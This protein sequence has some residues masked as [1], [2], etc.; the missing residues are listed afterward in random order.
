M[1][2]FQFLNSQAS[3][4]TVLLS[5]PLIFISCSETKEKAVIP[6]TSE[7]APSDVSPKETESEKAKVK[8]TILAGGY[9][10]TYT[11]PDGWSPELSTPFRNINFSFA[12]QGEVYLSETRGG[13]LPNINRWY[14]QL[15]GSSIESLDQLESFSVLSGKGYLVSVEGAF[16]SMRMPQA[17][18]GYMLLGVLVEID[19]ELTTVKMIGPKNE[20]SVQKENLVAFCKSL[21]RKK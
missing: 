7:E 8:T 20:V 21:E 9:Q 16:K 19:G 4:V 15:G 5:V 11:M 14:G 2:I 6:S 12:T 3:K 17:K 1:H 10:Y 18:P 13:V